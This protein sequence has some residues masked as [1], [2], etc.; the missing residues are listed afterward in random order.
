[1]SISHVGD[2]LILKLLNGLVIK[3][4]IPG[5]FEN[6]IST[7]L[8]TLYRL[9]IQWVNQLLHQTN[10]IRRET[11]HW[12]GRKIGLFKMQIN[13]LVGSMSIWQIHRELILKK[14]WNGKRSLII[15]VE[16]VLPVY[17]DAVGV[18]YRIQRPY[19][20]EYADCISV[21]TGKT[22]LT[23]VVHLTLKHLMVRVNSWSFGECGVALHCHYSQISSDPE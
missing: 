22:S 3:E 1:M 2:I 15:V 20:V 14:N 9:Y 7:I 12:E 19:S 4:Y 13:P 8:P 6:A 10:L 23:I 5:R 11:R 21:D 17:R 18:F 16:E